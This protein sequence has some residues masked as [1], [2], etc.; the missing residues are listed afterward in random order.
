MQGVDYT[1]VAV[2]VVAA[3][4][5]GVAVAWA[6]RRSR[7]KESP[8]DLYTAGLN[9]LL[10]G[11]KDRALEAFRKSVARNT[12]NIDAY[13]RIGD[14][15]R[16]KGQTL[17]AIK[18]HRELTVRSGLTREQLLTIY[19]SLVEDYLAAGD[20]EK[21][22]AVLLK[23]LEIQ[24]ENLWAVQTL[25]RA[26]EDL[27]DWEKAAAWRKKLRSIQGTDQSRILGL[28]KVEQGREAVRAGKEKAARI[29]F[30][31]AIKIDPACAPAYLELADSYVREAREGDALKV[32]RDFVR[33]APK[34]AYLA[35]SRIEDVLF[36][37]GQ[38]GE[39]E[40]IL[41]DLIAEHPRAVRARLALARIHEKR[42]EIDEAIQ[43]CEE[44]LQHEPGSMAARSQLIRLYQKNGDTERALQ[45][46][47][48]IAEAGAEERAKFECST[49]GYQSAE[50]F[51]RCPKCGAWQPA[52]ERQ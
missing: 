18:I 45:L 21:A 51:W 43:L 24:K 23:M 25:I 28:Y 14:I 6:I 32:L 20:R 36:K 46:A 7:S 9:Y 27:G 12:A 2:G 39:V 11:E 33:K 38:F 41:R 31:E 40:K 15:L 52:F 34:Q 22:A 37:V 4:I 35:F 16:E 8:E 44:A 29:R 30:R 17:R 19:R 26:Y 49:C 10:A 47:S 48:E 50:F 1:Y 42:G 5:L 13:I 3:V